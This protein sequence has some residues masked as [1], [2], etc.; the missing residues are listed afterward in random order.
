MWTRA[1]LVWCLIFALEALHGVAR[2]LWLVPRVGDLASRQIGVATGSLL[3]LAVAWLTATWLA[4]PCR[5]AAWRIGALWVA[6]TIAGEVLLG[7]GVF[8][9][10]WSRLIEDYDITRGGL[11]G[12]GMAVLLAAPWLAARWRGLPGAH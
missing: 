10:P 6:L 12:L 5:T 7:R 3:I 1:V 8:G 9:Y 11:L 2:T 4:A